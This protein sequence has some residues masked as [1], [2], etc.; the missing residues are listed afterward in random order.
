[1]EES[2]HWIN[3]TELSLVVTEGNSDTNSLGFKS[4]LTRKMKDSDFR[5]LLD[6]V[7]SSNSDDRF[8]LLD[9]GLTFLP[10]E[11]P[12]GDATTVVVPASELD[13]EKYFLEGRYTRELSGRRNWNVGASWDRNEDSGILNR[14]IVFGGAGTNWKDGEKLK[15]HTG[16]GGSYTDREE[17]SP[18]P[19]KEA[20]FFGFR[21]TLDLD[22]KVLKTTTLSYKLTGNLN[23]EDR[24]DYSID[25][26]ASVSVAMNKRLSLQA[27]LQ[28]LFNSEPALE[29]VDVFARLI[30]VDP[31]GIPGTGD[32]YFE[33]VTEGGFE[34]DIGEDRIRKERLD[35][36]FRTSLVI[37]F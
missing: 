35:T 5:L 21:G 12:S 10:G 6:S 30:T 24:S 36:V 15:F 1:M 16:Y 11:S 7:R 26:T 31:D 8:L 9:P 20:Q 23:L 17:D 18:D 2:K 13:V 25:T 33:T 19:E 22:Y 28:F 37:T 14:Y 29:D 27:G 34:I 3:A 32:E 4:T